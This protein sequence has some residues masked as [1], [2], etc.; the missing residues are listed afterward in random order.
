[1]VADQMIDL[2]QIEERMR[3]ANGGYAGLSEQE[4]VDLIAEVRRLRGALE[5]AHAH[6]NYHKFGCGQP[7]PCDGCALEAKVK[8]ALKS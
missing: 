3:Y 1:M 8:A 5:I 6:A 4:A 7:S 2:T